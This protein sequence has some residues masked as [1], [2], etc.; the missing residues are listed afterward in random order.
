MS[1]RFQVSRFHYK[2]S[3]NLLLLIF[4]SSL[5]GEYVNLVFHFLM[6]EQP[7]QGRVQ[8]SKNRQHSVDRA[9]LDQNQIE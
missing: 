6:T 4:N 7:D 8:K 5:F 2:N 1:F 9:F 3:A